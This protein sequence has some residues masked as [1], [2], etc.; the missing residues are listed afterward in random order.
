MH[1]AGGGELA[2]DESGPPAVAAAGE[3]AK[4]GIGWRGRGAREAA[5]APFFLV[6]F[7]EYCPGEFHLG[8]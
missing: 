2:G 6:G 8:A 3:A 5:P 7:L 1:Q 4:G